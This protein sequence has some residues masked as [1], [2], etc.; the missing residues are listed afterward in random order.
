MGLGVLGKPDTMDYRRQ[1][2]WRGQSW[3]ETRK[4]PIARSRVKK[5]SKGRGLGGL[6]GRQ[7]G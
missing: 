3:Q 6:G 5:P 1:A 2:G 7:R 4:I